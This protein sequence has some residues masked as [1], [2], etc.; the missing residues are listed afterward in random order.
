MIARRLIWVLLTSAGLCA[1]FAVSTGS[2]DRGDQ[3]ALRFESHAWKESLGIDTLH[4]RRAMTDD[5]VRELLSSRPERRLVLEALGPPWAA[6]S[7]SESF[8]YRIGTRPTS[9]T[10]LLSS[11]IDVF[12]RV[13]FDKDGRVA[14]CEVR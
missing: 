1:A 3:A 13:R 14:A 2:C 7:T 8:L 11:E 5:L 10:P 6:S 9:C 12:L 4:V